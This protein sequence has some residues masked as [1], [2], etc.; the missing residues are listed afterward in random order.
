MTPRLPVRT[1][2]P[3]RDCEDALALARQA[4]ALLRRAG[5]SRSFR[6]MQLTISSIRGAIRNAGYREGRPVPQTRGGQ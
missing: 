2:A 4:A 6:R 1:S 3:V 5:A